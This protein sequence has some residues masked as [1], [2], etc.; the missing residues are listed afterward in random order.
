MVIVG[1]SV[2]LI[3]PKSANG[4]TTMLIFKKSIIQT[5]RVE[6]YHL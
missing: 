5:R 1:R 3:N 6:G 4:P 2:E